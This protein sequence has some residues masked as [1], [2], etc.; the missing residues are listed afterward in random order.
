ML[1]PLAIAVIGGLAIAT[2]V[3][4]FVT[5]SVYYYLTHRHRQWAAAAVAQRALHS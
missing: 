5:F 1:K 2:I 4:L 3:S